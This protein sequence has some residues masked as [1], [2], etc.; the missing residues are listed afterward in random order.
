MYIQ[1]QP[2]KTKQKKQY[3]RKENVII[4]L[5][6]LLCTYI[7]IYKYINLFNNCLEEYEIGDKLIEKISKLGSMLI[8][9]YI[10]TIKGARFQNPPT[11]I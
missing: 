4:L 10:I 9:F 6:M 1:K 2:N 8:Y 11:L 5:T 3:Q 7:N